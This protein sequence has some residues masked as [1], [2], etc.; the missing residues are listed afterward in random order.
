MTHMDKRNR[1]NGAAQLNM[2][3]V[4]AKLDIQR[5]E[6]VHNGLNYKSYDKQTF[7]LNR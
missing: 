1:H 7:A 6:S 5:L 2:E 3:P 4:G